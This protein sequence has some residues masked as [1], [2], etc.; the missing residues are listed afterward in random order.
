MQLQDQ[1]IT[2]TQ[3]ERLLELWFMKD[4]YVVDK[5]KFGRK[6]H[7]YTAGEIMD[8]LPF[9]INNEE[10]VIKRYFNRI[11][12]YD[13]WQT[14]LGRHENINLTHALWDML[15]YLIENN[16]LPNQDK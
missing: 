3:A 11:V 7:L 1:V 5:D 2:K 4:S 15:I 8:I 13:W 6:L 16:L 9:S 12:Y 10:L 14:T